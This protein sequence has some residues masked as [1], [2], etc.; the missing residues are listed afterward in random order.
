VR[1]TAGGCL[2]RLG[3]ALLDLEDPR[4]V[5][6]RS[7]EWIFAPEAPYERQGD[8]DDVVFPCGW[9]LDKASGE[10]RLYYGG[11]DTCLALATARVSD[12]LSYLRDCPVPEERR[13]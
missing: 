2:Y 5:L 4:R 9:I 10:I 1:Q 8:V 6:R 7:D 11:G 12:L 13:A 3:L